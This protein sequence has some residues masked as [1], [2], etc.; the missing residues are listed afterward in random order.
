VAATAQTRR[1]P[2]WQSKINAEV[3]IRGDG[4]PLLWL[5]GPWG[6]PTDLAFVDNLARTNTV[7]APRHPGTS[8][9][10]TEAVGHIENWWDLILYY[11]ELLDALGLTDPVAVAGHSFGGML[12]CE[13]AAAMPNRISRLALIDSLGLWADDQPV[14]NWMILSPDV[15]R[16]SLFADPNGAAAQTFFALPEEHSAR[17][18]VQAAFIWAQASTGK[19]VWPIPDKG[20]KRHIHRIAA[21]TLIV[22]GKADGIIPPSYADILAKHIAGARVQTIEGAGHLPHLEKPEEVAATLKSFLS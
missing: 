1:L 11:G 19:F 18:D 17:A 20:L 12:A 16:R 5:H 21:P 15:L 6:L 14:K 10:D 3:E 9:G 2:V 13:L 8:T 22:W 4:P 7:Y